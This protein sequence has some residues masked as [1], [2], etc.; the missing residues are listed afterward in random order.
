[1]L[2]VLAGRRI[3]APDARVKRFPLAMKDV[4]YERILE[5]YKS[6]RVT[7]LVSSA[8]CGAD[9]LAQAAAR[10]LNIERHIILPF[11]RERFRIT[12]V[13]DRPGDWGNLFDEVCD[14]AEKTGN[15]TIMRGLSDAAEA[16][17]AVTD[18]LLRQANL[19]HLKDEDIL[20]VAVW[21]G[22]V[23]DTT[24]FTSIFI[25][26]ARINKIDVRTISTE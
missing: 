3:D 5:L 21:D 7:V 20:A 13:I 9:L 26:R 25:D 12:S 10:Q 6:E 2:I 19:I 24:D 17:S 11:G 8:A 4:V 14:E 1:M 23:N 15:L 22:K 18:E 16:Y